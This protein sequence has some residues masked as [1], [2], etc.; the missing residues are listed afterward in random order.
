MT[1]W[2]VYLKKIYS[3]ITL[4]NLCK[5]SI[6]QLR[7]TILPVVRTFAFPTNMLDSIILSSFNNN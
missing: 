7:S 2:L 3:I 6:H 1:H 5:F 4:I